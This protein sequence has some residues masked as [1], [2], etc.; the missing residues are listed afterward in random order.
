MK[1][2]VSRRRW[3]RG[4]EGVLLNSSGKMCCLGFGA[5]QCGVKAKDIRGRTM[6]AIIPV[7]ARTQALCDSPLLAGDYNS[8]LANAASTINDD[9]AISDKERETK[10]RDLFAG[11]GHQ[12]VFVP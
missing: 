4:G 7:A 10:L 3:L 2:R 5:R 1:I 12:I 9:D 6:P 11:F 8:A